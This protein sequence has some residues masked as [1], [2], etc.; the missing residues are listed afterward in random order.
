M[1]NPLWF[2]L[3]TT[4]TGLALALSACGGGAASS[5][6]PATPALAATAPSTAAASPG[7]G[8]VPTTQMTPSG[9][10]DLVSTFG[11]KAAGGDYHVVGL[12][13]NGTPQAL[14]SIELT[15]ELKDASGKTLL[16]D[17]SGQSV[18]SVKF[19][20][21]LDTLAPGENS[22]FDYYVNTADVGEPA[23]N[24]FNVRITGEQPAQVARANVAVEDL[25]MVA[26]TSGSSYITGELINRDSKPAQITSY[27][28]A[29]LDDSNQVVA[30][31]GSGALTRLLAPA[32]DSSG[33]DRTA[34][35]FRLDTPG[36]AAKN[37]AMYL[38][39]VQPDNY[40]PSNVN[41]QVTNAYFDS[42]HDYHI[43]GTMTNND[44]STLTVRLVAGLYAQDGAPLDADTLDSVID[45]ASGQSV[46]FDFRSFSVVGSLTDQAAKLDHHTVQVDP[47]WTF[48]SANE[49]VPLQTADDKK[50]DNGG[51]Q[52]DLSG[53]ITNTS[54]KQLSSVTVVAAVFDPQGKLVATESTDVSSTGDTFA[55]HEKDPYD[56]SIYL[57]PAVDA[58]SYTI[59]TFAQGILK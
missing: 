16:R 43:V 9:T 29:A 54:G 2:V 46:P 32:G 1:K 3:F 17:S 45:L 48:A 14:G 42:N 36:E 49:T 6:T 34:F 56:V 22:P 27:A 52:W 26:D 33:N 50:T 15:L 10:L 47:Y 59:K 37:P 11:Y 53:T 8:P 7:V 24:G 41:V 39:A 18:P 13:H 40:A 21:A 5:V 30:E 19:S 57:D 44:K 20:P 23:Q 55:A 28:A 38:D 51:G 35:S 31:S 25:H 12:I 58:G 4:C